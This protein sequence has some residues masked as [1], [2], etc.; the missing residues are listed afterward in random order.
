[1]IRGAVLDT[2]CLQSG[3]FVI[4]R[5]RLCSKCNDTYITVEFEVKSMSIFH[6]VLN[7]INGL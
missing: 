5:Q 3:G 4:K 7:R 2:R 1:M 6:S